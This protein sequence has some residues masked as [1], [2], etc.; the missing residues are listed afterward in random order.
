MAWRRWLTAI[1]ALTWACWAPP[2]RAAEPH[3]VP[4]SDLIL[5]LGAVPQEIPPY[6]EAMKDRRERQVSGVTYWIGHIGKKPVAVALT[7]VGKVKAATVTT[8]LVTALHPRVVLMSGTGSRPNPAMRTGDVIV[9]TDLYEHD[10]GS[11]TRNDM[12]YPDPMEQLRPPPPLLAAADRAIATYDRPEVTANGQTYRINVRRGVVVSSDLFGVTDA[13]I[14]TIRDRFHADIME[15]E[16]A[17]FAM[18]CKMIGVDCIVV[19]A[20]SNVSQEA[21]SDDYKRLGPIAAKQAAAFGI[22]LIGYL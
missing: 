5:V 13:R 17:A 18:S 8:L 6:V 7:G 22:H 1:F 3:Y 2:V 14:Q 11:L 19:R 9:A 12:V 15:M 16:S 20:G 4:S 10:A 21:P